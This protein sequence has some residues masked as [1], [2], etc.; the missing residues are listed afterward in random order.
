MGNWQTRDKKRNNK[1]REKNYK[2]FYNQTIIDAGSDKNLIRE[3][4]KQVELEQEYDT[5]INN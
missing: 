3:K 5:D 2:K 4:R 1:H